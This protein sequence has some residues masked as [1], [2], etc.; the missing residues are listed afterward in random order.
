MKDILSFSIRV[1]IVYY[2][3]YLCTRSLSKKSMAQMTASDI[4]GILILINVA[5]EPLVDKVIVKSV[6]GS[7]LL[8]VL[9]MI[10]SRLSLKK[11]FTSILEHSP[12]FI[13]KNGIFNKE[14]LD[15]LGFSINEFEGLLRQQGY[16]KIYDLDKVI[17]EPQ[18]NISVFP[19]NENKPVTLKDLNEN[20]NLQEITI[21]IIIDGYILYNNLKH[22]QKN[23]EW[24][25]HELKKQGILDYKKEVGIAEVDT[26][27]RLNISRK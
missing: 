6:Y 27:W 9:M 14:A 4:A 19:K 13:V 16:D 21:P 11:K 1:I 20:N 7:G 22:I 5:T 3:T 10:I 18:G 12:T 26:N 23:K 24:L 2:F 8:V 17:M 15:K 25:S